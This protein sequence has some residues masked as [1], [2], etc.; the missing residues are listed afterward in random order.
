M[1]IAKKMCLREAEGHVGLGTFIGEFRTPT[2]AVI[3]QQNDFDSMLVGT[4][5]G[6]FNPGDVGQYIL[7][8][9]QTGVCSLVRVSGPDQAEIKRSSTSTWCSWKE[10]T[11]SGGDG[12]YKVE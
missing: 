7:A 10:R 9:K 8:S 4:E 11:S 12:G 6:C 5:H 3:L 1:E 2:V